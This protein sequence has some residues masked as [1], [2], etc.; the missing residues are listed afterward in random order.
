[1]SGYTA[2]NALTAQMTREGIRRLLVLSGEASWCHE[3][4]QHLRDALPGDW[5]WV[6][7][8]RPPNPAARRWR[9]KRYWDVNSTM[10][11][12]TLW[13]GLMRRPLLP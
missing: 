12:S 11:F 7:L 5:L 1:M 13:P 3:Q 10:P 2:L 4:V 8:M 9:C 6:S